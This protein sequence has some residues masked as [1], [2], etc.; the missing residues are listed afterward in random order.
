ME[1]R[2][3]LRARYRAE[4]MFKALGLGAIGVSVGFLLFLFT[5]IFMQ[6][7]PAFTHNF[8]ALPLEL[9]AQTLGDEGVISEES[10]SGA[11]YDAIVRTAIR[12]Q[13]PEVSGRTAK[14]TLSGLISPGAP[15]LLREALLADPERRNAPNA[16][17]LPLSDFADLYL[18]GQISRSTYRTGE[19]ELAIE[20]SETGVLISGADLA[21]G[22]ESSGADGKI[23]LSR[24]MPSL[25]L[26]AGGGVFK[27]ETLEGNLATARILSPLDAGE[28][29]KALDW[30]VRLIEVPE[31]NRK[32]S[33]R[34]IVWT[35]KLVERQL[36]QA[37]FN[38][39]FFTRGAS[40]EPEMAGILGA[41]VGTALTLVV[42]LGLSFPLGVAAA[43]YLEEFA[44]RNRLTAL[45][46]VNI[47][48]LAAVPSIVFG[49]LGL[50]VFLTFFGMPR[51][52]PLVGG[53]VLAL[54]TL[55]TIII[56]SRAALRAVPPS[57]REAALGIG[58]SK[59]QVVVHHVL[60]LAM[61]GILTGTIIGMAQALG[62][63]APLLMIGMVAFVVDIPGGFTDP[64][65][66]LP[67]QIFM[68]ADFPEPAF[69]QRT[70]AAIMVLLAFLVVMNALAVVLRKQFER[71]W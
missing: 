9:N 52:A 22:L 35:D 65:T 58:A 4:W 46:E 10:L 29:T 18:K 17:T 56:A 34:E 19:G 63:T 20:V 48:N 6:G 51:S 21:A 33:D 15:V 61:P 43:V 13:F 68:W 38:T 53:M 59:M 70:S 69:Q 44:P 71:R 27:L 14:R 42:T 3:R 55:P 1:A 57:I 32:F 62:E 28:T 7:W 23:S 50:A 45:V 5:T 67:V 39:L 66:V 37:K 31:A 47:N 16:I 11:D 40:R 26:Y 49:L 60:P 41:V 36:V 8:V 64:A 24:E 54:M 12:E 25:L 30:Q 2:E